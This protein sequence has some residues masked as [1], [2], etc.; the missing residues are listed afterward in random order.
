MRKLIAMISVA[1]MLG[2]TIGATNY[3]TAKATEVT[4]NEDTG[5]RKQVGDFILTTEEDYY[6]NPDDVEGSKDYEDAWW[7]E[8]YLGNSSKVIIPDE[9][10]GKKIK[11]LKVGIFKNHTELEEIK[12]PKALE[13]IS[14]DTFSGCS[15]LKE[16][17]IPENVNRISKYAFEKC[18]NLKTLHLPNA[19]CKVDSS[20]FLDSGI[21]ELTIDSNNSDFTTVDGVLYNKECTELVISPPQKSKLELPETVKK[22]NESAFQDCSALKTVKLSKTLEIIE[23]FAFN[24]CTA[25]EKVQLPDTVTE[26]KEFAF[27][28]CSAL[29]EVKFSKALEK[30]SEAV[31]KNCAALEKVELPDTVTGINESAFEGCSALK[32]VKFSNKLEYISYDA[33]KGCSVL[34]EVK[35]PNTLK[36]IGSN[37]F[38]DCK[39]IEDIVIPASVNKLMYDTFEGC[40]NIKT[41][42]ISSKNKAYSTSNGD[43]YNK[44]KTIFYT[45]VTNK[46]IISI[47]ASVKEVKNVFFDYYGEKIKKI[48][49]AKGNKYYSIYDDALYD[50]NKKR[51]YFCPKNKISIIL[52]ATLNVIG[53][54]DYNT[55]DYDILDGEKLRKIQVKAANKKYCSYKGILY[56]KKKTKMLCVP[57]GITNIVIPKTI[58]SNIEELKRC[59]DVKS[60]KVEAG[61]KKFR[62]KDGV[63]YNAGFTKVL[64]SAN[65]KTIILPKTVKTID[66]FAFAGC[67]KLKNI[68]LPGKVEYIGENAFGGCDKLKNI[69]LPGKLKYVGENA[70]RGCSSL[71]YV[72]F[73]NKKVF[74]GTGAFYGCSNLKWVYLPKEVE[75]GDIN[76]KHIFVLCNNLSDIYYA[77]T[78][79]KW[80]KSWWVEGED[81]DL[82]PDYDNKYWIDIDETIFSDLTI[83]YEAKA[84]L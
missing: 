78:E 72:K 45:S 33:F 68:T 2:S 36:D 46:E 7:I 58:T 50:K 19:L 37:A 31:F 21:E 29:K 56:N 74:I 43:L 59:C 12:L 20:A 22:I 61:N 55:D 49:V 51:L 13:E 28:D 27:K 5:V 84:P 34:K 77:G 47:P 25:L 3:E 44:N 11:G 71:H 57:G 9:Y 18:I 41:F 76:E 65:K 69:T 10:Q 64:F 6:Y 8:E 42:K 83:H 63:L 73:P 79:E 30:I 14:W 40:D 35:F 48:K 70:F 24:N 60:I 75:F 39:N 52:P 66:G 26:I 4:E 38:K 81:S 53:T 23:E 15:N 62:A 54:M 17:E 32:E 16:I 1:A 67:A 82:H 80:K